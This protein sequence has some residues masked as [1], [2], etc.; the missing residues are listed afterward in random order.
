MENN[1]AVS[2]LAALAQENRLAV[3]RLLVR[4]APEGLTPGVIGEQ[5]ELP[6]PTLSFHLKTL[7]QAGLVTAIQEGRFVRYRAEMAGI[8]ALI[9][10][11]TEDCCCGHPQ[12]CI[13]KGKQE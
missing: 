6:A 2:A 11:L 4:N 7:A 3:F 10:F 5:L 1:N 12:L 8:N 9:D 13:P